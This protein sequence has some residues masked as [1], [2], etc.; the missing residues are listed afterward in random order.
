MTKPDSQKSS[1]DSRVSGE[2]GR[3]ILRRD[4]R[5]H[6]FRPIS[7][8]SVETRNRI[9]LSPMCQYSAVDG[10]PNDWHLVHLGARAVGGA[11][12][13]CTEAVHVAPHGRITQHDLGLWNDDQ[14]SLIH[15]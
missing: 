1:T 7:F 11:G 14:L 6:L 4:P 2:D 8:R 3:R 9:M 13:V 12:I 5:P 15:I 10:M